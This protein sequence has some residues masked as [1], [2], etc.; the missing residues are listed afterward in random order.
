MRDIDNKRGVFE[1][2]WKNAFEEAEMVPS[3]NVWNKVD[4]FLA[5][6]ESKKYR[7]GIFYYKWIAAASIVLSLGIGSIYFLNERS[8][9]SPNTAGNIQNESNT[10]QDLSEIP[11]NETSEGNQAT[12]HLKNQQ[13]VVAQSNNETLSKSESTDDKAQNNSSKQIFETG[14][15]SQLLANT[16]VDNNQLIAA[17]INTSKGND[18]NVATPF[19]LETS[20]EPFGLT[21]LDNLG[22]NVNET[23]EGKTIAAIEK[24]P[25]YN[26]EFFKKEDDSEDPRDNL[27]ASLNMSS[28]YFDPNIGSTRG[29][30][31]VEQALQLDGLGTNAQI[32]E[33][34]SRGNTF[35]VGFNMGFKIAKK[36]IVQSGVN[37]LNYSAD[38]QTN[39]FLQD[40][41]NNNRVPLY[42]GLESLKNDVLDNATNSNVSFASIDLNNQFQF[43][44]IPVK[45]GYVLLNKKVSLILT[46]G[47]STD[48]LIENTVSDDS[49]T[50]DEFTIKPGVDSPYRSVYFN[51]LIG[52]QISYQFAK[53]YSFSLEPLYSIAINSFSKSDNNLNSYPSS[54]NVG[55]GIKYHF[56]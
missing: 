42:S 21:S 50:V 51:G 1:E 10:Q 33:D 25:V 39:A 30:A 46:S 34:N 41:S 31:N 55:I 40:A 23:E 20:T 12:D 37:Y 6:E 52:T 48:F 29:V 4:N 32:R 9:I 3:E 22:A 56:K 13:N 15:E 28:G 38:A 49:N 14:T 35:T 17:D 5:N 43:V 26:F 36:W 2:A 44:S 11:T 27:W 47:V 19:A 16:E 8:D 7:K 53:N 18:V 54:L 24:V 45:M